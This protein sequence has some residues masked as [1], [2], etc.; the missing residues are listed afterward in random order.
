MD[1]PQIWAS[2][3]PTVARI[4]AHAVRD[5][6]AETGH[7]RREDDIDRLAALGIA[8]SRYPVLWEK[9][10]PFD[11]RECDFTWAQRRLER[12]RLRAVEPIVTLL[13]HGSG[14]RY[15]SLVDPAFPELFAQYARQAVR[16]FPWVER[17]TPINEP[18]TTARFST[19]YGVWFPNGN[20]DHT[21]F[22]HAIVYEALGSA[23]AMREI[24]AV[25][26]GAQFLLTED[27]QGFVAAD[28]GVEA[29]VR[30]KY[31]RSFLSYELLMGRLV[32]GHPLYRYLRD[33]CNVARALLERLSDD[34]CPPDIAGFNYYPNSERVVA[35]DG[36]ARSRNNALI[37]VDPKAIDPRALLRAAWNRLRIPMALS[38]VHIIG[39][40]RERARWMLQRFGDVQALRAEGVEICGFGPW[41]AFGL[42][43]WTSL[44]CERRDVVEDGIFTCARDGAEP[45]WT[46]VADVVRALAQGVM[47][48]IPSEPGWW[49]RRR[50]MSVA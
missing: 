36:H 22:G 9:C 15:T 34:P 2:P 3:E 7:E 4:N 35:S 29:Y 5:Q 25:A 23:A 20:F 42:V 1:F 49:E 8:A 48:V 39:N 50:D 6:L 32:P 40:E 37:D 30:H 14:P 44:L 46:M 13:H 28:S 26:P 47:P 38:E 27:L 31:D 11:P 43:D 19:L 21:A 18:L 12:L 41:A 16:R 10:S 45:Q 17:W 24:R 33:E